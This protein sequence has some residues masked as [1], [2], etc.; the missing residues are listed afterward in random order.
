MDRICILICS[1]GALVPI[2]TPYGV[3]FH[4]LC[5]CACVLV[6][7]GQQT[8]HE[9]LIHGYIPRDMV[10]MRRLVLAHHNVGS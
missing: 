1:S 10:V 9:C 4:L 5:M 3:Y 6:N 7:I 2:R 8:L